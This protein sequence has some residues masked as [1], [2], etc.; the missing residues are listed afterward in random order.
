MKLTRLTDLSRIRWVNHTFAYVLLEAGYD[1]AES[2]AKADYLELYETVKQ[3]KQERQIYKG[4]IGANDMKLCVE[5]ARGLS[6][7]LVY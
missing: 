6:F 5:A 2:V 3:L 1:T 4:N 7:E